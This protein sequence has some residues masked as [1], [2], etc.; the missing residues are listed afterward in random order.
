MP[1]APGALP[2]GSRHPLRHDRPATA[3]PGAEL[4][5]ATGMYRAMAMTLWLS[6]AEAALAQIGKAVRPAGGVP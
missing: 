3:G 2:P 5:T 6:Q 4:S 1:A